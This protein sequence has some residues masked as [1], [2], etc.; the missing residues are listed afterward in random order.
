MTTTA[1]A[2]KTNVEEKKVLKTNVE[3]LAENVLLEADELFKENAD[4]KVDD[5]NSIIQNENV[6][7]HFKPLVPVYFTTRGKGSKNVQRL[8]DENDTVQFISFRLTDNN[9]STHCYRRPSTY[10]SSSRVQRSSTSRVHWTRWTINNGNSIDLLRM[11]FLLDRNNNDNNGILFEYAYD[12]DAASIYK[13]K[14]KDDYNDDDDDDDN[15]ND[16]SDSDSCDVRDLNPMFGEKMIRV[17]HFD[18]GN[19]RIDNDVIKRKDEKNN[20]EI[21]KVVSIKLVNVRNNFTPMLVLNIKN[22]ND[23]KANNV[24]YH[25]KLKEKNVDLFD[26]S[27]KENKLIQFKFERSDNDNNN[28]RIETNNLNSFKKGYDNLVKHLANNWHLYFGLFGGTLLY[29]F[30]IDLIY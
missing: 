29:C 14:N 4:F 19:V 7:S 21:V 27:I 13:T 11:T 25:Q 5:D 24:K 22:I 26:V 20:L 9:I 12:G 17:P 30:L 16:D 8:M 6:A 1:L 3:K 10:S 28:K 2:E 15:D 18:V 23:E